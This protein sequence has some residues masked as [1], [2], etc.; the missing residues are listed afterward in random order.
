[1]R[2]AQWPFPVAAA[3]G[4]SVRFKGI[5]REVRLRLPFPVRA[6]LAS[7]AA[8]FTLRMP[9]DQEGAFQA[10]CE[11]IETV[12]SGIDTLPVLP[13]E[14]E[15]ILTILP[16]ERLKWTKDGRLLSAGTKTVKMRGRAKAVT[17][18]VHDPRHI[19]DVLDRDMPTAWREADA[20][21]TAENRRKGAGKAALTRSGKSGPKL[22]TARRSK[23]DP[24]AVDLA[25]WREFDAE[26]FLR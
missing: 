19:E 7:D 23:R 17:F 20:A 4:S 10:A 16:R 11:T 15:E 18:H 22:P 2:E 25:G 24:E 5:D 6:Y 1:M 12:L 14:A 3:M 8:V 26:G 21:E 9:D 13:S